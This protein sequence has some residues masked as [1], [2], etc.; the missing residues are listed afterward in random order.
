MDN[1]TPTRAFR[2]VWLVVPPAILCALDFGL[3]LYGQS[4]RY[5][6]GNYTDVNEMSPSFARYL[7][8][9]PLAFVAAGCRSSAGTD[10]AD[11][12]KVV[13][14]PAG[15]GLYTIAKIY[16]WYSYYSGRLVKGKRKG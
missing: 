5:W 9:H 11:K 6:A 4:D 3:T 2:A 8:I 7:A 15:A 12:A 16:S 10:S 14:I 1:L 13:P